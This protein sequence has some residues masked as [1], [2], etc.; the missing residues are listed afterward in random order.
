MALYIC[1]VINVAIR[2]LLI[3]IS[4]AFI[5]VTILRVSS[6]A[7]RHRTF[8]TC[9]SH[10]MVV[11]LMYSCSSFICLH[12]S[13]SYFPE[14]G[15]IVSMVYTF[16]TPILSPWSY[17]MRNKEVKDALSRALGRR[18]LHQNPSTSR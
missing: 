10:L 8:S 2:F 9:S 12:P 1:S 7:G 5:V 17:S 18:M 6:G 3:C 13:S 15:R 11:A 4:Y 16:V 14:Q